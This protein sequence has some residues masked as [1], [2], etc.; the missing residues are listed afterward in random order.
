[1]TLIERVTLLRL[2]KEAIQDWCGHEHACCHV[3]DALGLP[4]WR[5]A[6]EVAKHRRRRPFLFD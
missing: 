4:A 5:V 3:G 1:M 6:V 2:Y